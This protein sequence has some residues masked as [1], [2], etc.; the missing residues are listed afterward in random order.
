MRV[1]NSLSI[2]VPVYNAADYL[3]DCIDSILLQPFSD[4]ELIL[5]ND[6]SLDQSAAI[7]DSYMKR[8]SRIK[9]FHKKNGGV[10]SARNYGIKNAIGKYLCFI[11]SDDWVNDDFFLSFGIQKGSESDIYVQGYRRMRLGKAVGNVGYSQRKIDHFL[12]FFI[13]SE[14]NNLFNSPCFKLF[15]RDIIQRELILFD[16]RFSLGEDHIF[17]LQYLFF[18][19]TFEISTSRGYNYRVGSNDNSLTTRL[20]DVDMFAKYIEKTHELRRSIADKFGFD[21]INRNELNRETNKWAVYLCHKLLDARRKIGSRELEDKIDKIVS[22]MIKPYHLPKYNFKGNVYNWLFCRVLT[23]DLLR[24]SSKI[25]ML[26]II[27]KK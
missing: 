17:T 8:D 25:L 14:K 18:C 7:C 26:K 5:V 22:L 13:L 16:E 1:T 21:P 27:I 9:V 2:I 4:F 12:D 23:S 15:R 3:S 10:S 11:D 20:V 19:E 24:N 6:G